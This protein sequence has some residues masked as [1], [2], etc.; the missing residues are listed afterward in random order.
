[1]ISFSRLG[2]V[3][4]LG[5]NLFQV[6][7]TLGLSLSK[8]RGC[9]FPEWKYARYFAGPFPVGP[10]AGPLVVEP[11]Y[12]Y[13]DF[14][15]DTPCDLGD[16]L[17]SERYWAD[18]KAEVLKRFEWEPEFLAS[19]KEK[20]ERVFLRKVICVSCRRGDIVDNPNYALL[21]AMY[22]ITA[23]YD[24]FPD[25]KDCNIL[26][27]SDD[28][29]WCRHHFGCLDNAFFADD[30]DDR[31]YFFSEKAV[32]QLCLG[33]LCDG[34]VLSNSTF[35]WWCAYLAQRGKVVRPTE[36][37]AGALAKKCDTRDLWPEDWIAHSARKFDLSDVTF[38]VPVFCD[39]IDRKQNLDISICMVQ[40]DF[41]TNVIIGEQ[42]SDRFGYFRQWCRYKRFDLPD[43][44]RTRML[45][46]MAGMSSTPI[47]VNFDCDILLPPMQVIL[48]AEAIRSG[49]ADFC[50]PYDGRFA[51]VPRNPWFKRMEKYLDTGIMCN[52]DF[53]G[54]RPG[55]ALSVGGCIFANRDKF[56]E[57]G[58]ENENMVSWGPEDL[59]RVHRWEKLGYTVKRI[60]GMLFHL[61]H[62]TGA[63]SSG[64]NPHFKKNN[65]EYDR[66]QA[67]SRQE[68]I[69][70]VKSWKNVQR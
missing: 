61:D 34:F 29:P 24:H 4:R 32:E 62:Q 2:T 36:Y 65:R 21:P 11:S 31:D 1:M 12:H 41:E 54:T 40:R 64:R 10:K 55:D 63:N 17:Q 43:F 42:G 68:L 52:E 8:G 35:S 60:K 13:S 15:P 45:N 57:S 49:E 66:I 9:S 51:R 28:I 59:E 37:F 19:I 48:A 58:G 33:S 23:L 38:T 5:N 67:M 69:D 56:F 3:G 20:Y 47:V 16:Y 14:V 26:F 46:Q 18:N 6:A 70:Y 22:Y 53:N 44:W 30:F 39:S 50:F 25:W 27:L 7:S